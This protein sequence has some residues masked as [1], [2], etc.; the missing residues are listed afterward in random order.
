MARLERGL[1]DRAAR[2]A[3]QASVAAP[4]PQVFPSLSDDRLAGAIE[5]LQRLAAMRRGQ[6]AH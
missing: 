5:N 1:A 4:E 2:T 6:A 3:S